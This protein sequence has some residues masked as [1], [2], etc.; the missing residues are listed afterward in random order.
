[1]RGIPADR[2]DLTTSCISNS[3]ESACPYIQKETLLPL[4]GAYSKVK[5]DD[6]LCNL[7]MKILKIFGKGQSQYVNSIVKEDVTWLYYY[8][9][10]TKA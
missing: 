6:S 2:R 1:M 9:M 3:F 4:G 10:P 5:A 8:D 7:V